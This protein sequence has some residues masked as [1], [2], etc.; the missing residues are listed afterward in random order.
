[1]GLLTEFLLDWAKKG[2]VARN[3]L[4]ERIQMY[5]TLKAEYWRFLSD[6]NE[7]D[8]HN[9]LRELEAAHAW[10]KPRWKPGVGVNW[11]PGQQCRMRMEQAQINKGP[12]RARHQEFSY[13]A[14]L[15]DLVQ[16][17]IIQLEPSVRTPGSST[18]GAGPTLANPDQKLHVAHALLQCLQSDFPMQQ[19]ETMYGKGIV[20][21]PNALARLQ[22]FGFERL[23]RIV[24]YLVR[25]GESQLRQVMRYCYQRDLT[26]N[27]VVRYVYEKVVRPEEEK[28]REVLDEVSQVAADLLRKMYS[29]QYCLAYR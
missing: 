19:M 12:D 13:A 3:Y 9:I 2:P 16:D 11:Q 7:P 4:D 22:A 25:A 17:A 23:T 8:Y 24:D 5:N 14:A 26:R 29:A 10:L 6:L 20:H 27:S 28:D 21:D 15:E 18:A 1:M